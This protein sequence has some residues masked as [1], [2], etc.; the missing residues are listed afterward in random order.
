MKSLQVRIGGK[1]QLLPRGYCS[2]IANYLLTYLLTPYS[3]VLLEK[4]NGSQL[5]KNFPAL[6]GTRTLLP[7]LQVPAT[8]PY[9]ESDQ[10]NPCPHSTSWRSSLILSSHLRLGLPS[11]LFPSPLLTITGKISRGILGDIW[12]FSWYFKICTYLLQNFSGNL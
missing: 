7:R 4:L 2:N 6:Y 5:V 1:R 9:P 12:N 3:R 8:C 11:G 10:S